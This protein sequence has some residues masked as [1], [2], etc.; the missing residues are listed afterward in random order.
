MKMR[1]VPSFDMRKYGMAEFQC[2]N[3]DC[4]YSE[5]LIKIEAVGGKPHGLEGI[6]FK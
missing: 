2:S 1:M 6:K 4:F 5:N 3:E